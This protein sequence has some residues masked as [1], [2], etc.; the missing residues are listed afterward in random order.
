M[1]YHFMNARLDEI[2]TPPHRLDSCAYS[3]LVQLFS[4]VEPELLK[5]LTSGYTA[6]LNKKITEK[7]IG[8]FTKENPEVPL[9]TLAGALGIKF[10]LV[11]IKANPKLKHFLE[12]IPFGTTESPPTL[13]NKQAI[14]A[15]F[16]KLLAHMK[17]ANEPG[18]QCIAVVQDS[19][20]NLYVTGNGL[21]GFGSEFP[22]G[23]ETLDGEEIDI[24]RFQG[25]VQVSNPWF[26]SAAETMLAFKL[27]SPSIISEYSVRSV[28]FIAP[29]NGD[30]KGA[31]HCEM[32]LIDYLIEYQVLPVGRYIG[33][34]KPCCAHCVNSLVACGLRFWTQHGA[35][36]P[37][38][39]LSDKIAVGHTAYRD[40]ARVLEYKKVLTETYK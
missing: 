31:F 8:S 17:L 21:W 40:P 37:D 36:G 35:R 4:I 18:E 14:V 9:S 20:L 22:E 16:A 10:D 38:P 2:T 7:N 3:I 34:S 13:V 26:K 12:A 32:Q 28:N 5:I 25:G 23:S 27:I 33:V 11:R 6:T 15:A 19:D 39:K 29:T 30:S 24:T 1:S